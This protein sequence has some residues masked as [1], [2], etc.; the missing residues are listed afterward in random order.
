MNS[1][2][3]VVVPDKIADWYTK[4]D[5]P[6]SQTYKCNK[7]QLLILHLMKKKFIYKLQKQQQ[8]TG[9]ISYIFVENNI[10]TKNVNKISM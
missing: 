7:Q 6:I 8:I 5:C 3:N 9:I 2:N 10:K 1:Y 4:H